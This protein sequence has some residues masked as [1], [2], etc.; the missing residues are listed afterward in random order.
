VT[1]PQSGIAEETVEAGKQPQGEVLS[2]SEQARQRR[3]QARQRIERN[4][5]KAWFQSL[6]RLI[7]FAILLGIG[8]SLRLAVTPSLLIAAL[9]WTLLTAGIA[10]RYYQVHRPRPGA[11]EQPPG[12]WRP[13]QPP[14]A[15]IPDATMDAAT[16]ILARLVSRRWQNFQLEI[17]RCE[18]PVRHGLCREGWTEPIVGGTLKVVL[19]EHLAARPEV[20]SFVL[21]H[22]TRHPAGWTYQ[23]S[24]LTTYARICGWLIAPWAVPWPWVLAA[25]AAVQVAFAAACWIVE[26][27]CDLGGARAEGRAA[28][29]AFFA[30]RRTEG[31][32]PKP[33][34]AWLRYARLLLITVAVPTA[35]P[36]LWLRSAIISGLVPDRGRRG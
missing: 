32:E 4:S 35:H 1:T 6:V 21:A 31:R 2:K 34:P 18:D 29:L 23:L 33:G 24:V 20:A 9:T 28:A 19:G 36:P 5:R 30:H 27:G 11:T 14:P 25:V 12:T 17:A 16:R 26:T 15:G 3:E 13:G 8:S 7:Q 22:E 10:A